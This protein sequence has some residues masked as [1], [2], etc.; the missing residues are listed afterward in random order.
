MMFDE[1]NDVEL[2][3]QTH[4]FIPQGLHQIYC[5]LISQ[6]TIYEGIKNCTYLHCSYVNS[7]RHLFLDYENS[8]R[9]F[10]SSHHLFLPVGLSRT[11]TLFV[12]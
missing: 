12:I 1:I 2:S 4:R 5:T 11:I 9:N 10:H 6:T 3:A 7:R 8:K